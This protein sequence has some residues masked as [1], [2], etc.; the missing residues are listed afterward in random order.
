MTLENEPNEAVPW[1][2]S[3]RKFLVVFGA[4]AAAIAAAGTYGVARNDVVPA[5]G[6]AVHSAD[7]LQ[8]ARAARG[9]RLG[10]NGTPASTVAPGPEE[11]LRLVSAGQGGPPQQVAAGPDTMERASAVS[12]TGTSN[13]NPHGHGG[14]GGA[15][16]ATGYPQPGNETWGDVVV[17]EVEVF[18]QEEVPVP[19]SAGQLRLRRHGGETITPKDFS[20]RSGSIAPGAVESMWIS[21]LAPSD[22]EGFTLEFT[23]AF[24]GELLSIGIPSF[25]AGQS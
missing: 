21:Y 7:K 17:L 25:V 2:F 16:P 6:P 4:G 15:V 8:V 20:R 22:A 5:A 11:F 1:G 10:P 24:H 19:F 13:R 23:D 9:A 14:A 3:R 18:N 12:A